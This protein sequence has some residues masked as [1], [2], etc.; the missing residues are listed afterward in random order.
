MSNIYSITAVGCEQHSSYRSWYQHPSSKEY[1][2]LSLVAVSLKSCIQDTTH[3]TGMLGIFLT[4]GLFLNE[5]MKCITENKLNGTFLL[6]CFF[7]LE[8]IY[9]FKYS[10]ESTTWYISG[11]A[12]QQ[13]TISNIQGKQ[14]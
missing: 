11:G 2:V 14:L 5:Y 7:T 9:Y 6:M 12:V 10:S 8:C 3:K 13:N 4:Y 1:L